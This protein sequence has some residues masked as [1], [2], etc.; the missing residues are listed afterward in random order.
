MSKTSITATEVSAIY[1]TLDAIGCL[2]TDRTAGYLRAAYSNEESEAMRFIEGLALSLGGS[3]RWDSIGNLSIDWPGST[4]RYVEFGS[5]LDTVPR[6]GNFDGAAGVVAGLLAIRKIVQNDNARG[7]GLRLRIWRG[8]ESST[9]NTLYIGSLGAFGKFNARTLS[10]TFQGTTL[11]EAIKTQGY[12]PDV[13]RQGERTVREQEVD[14]IAAHFELHI[15]QGNVLEVRGVDLGIVTSIRGARRFRVTITGEFDHSGATPMGVEF[16]KDANLALAYM[17]I[18]LDKLTNEHIAHG[19]DLVQTVGVINS[20]KDFND[21]HPVVYE[22][23]IPKVS[24]YA[25]FCIDVRSSRTS[26]LEQFCEQMEALI[27]KVAADFRVSATVELL[28]SSTPLEEM[29]SST[30]QLLQS[31][32][33]NCGFSSLLLPSG[34][35]HDAAILGAQKRSDGRLVPVGMLFIP[36][37][38]GKSHSP[39]EFASMDAIAKGATALAQ[40]FYEIETDSLK[41]N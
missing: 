34:A 21:A 20:G 39:D 7:H 24:G 26:V 6:G 8:E 30:L 28:S 15:E 36:C 14:S 13:L 16:R 17:A 11:E 22:N 29:D 4:D 32:C 27:S 31:S 5:H 19:N 9:F 33:K 1:G 18:G 2:G 38:K 35:G 10:N 41:C 40:A 23:A 37:R 3:S 12:N 25:Y